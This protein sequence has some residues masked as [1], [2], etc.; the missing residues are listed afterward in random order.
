MSNVLEGTRNFLFSQPDAVKDSIALRLHPTSG[1]GYQ[2]FAENITYGSVDLHEGVDFLRDYDAPPEWLHTISGDPAVYRD[3]VMGKNVW[4]PA[5]PQFQQHLHQYVDAMK[6]VGHGLMRALA[7]GLGLRSDYFAKLTS[8]PYWSMR[9]IGY[10][11][12]MRA[13][14]VLARRPSS[15]DSVAANSVG[16][17]EHCDYGCWTLLAVDPNVQ[18]SLQVRAANGS[19]L[20]GDPVPGALVVNIGDLLSLWSGGLYQSTPHRVVNHMTLNRVS[21]PFFFDPNF[22]SPAAVLPEVQAALN[23]AKV[24][25]PRWATRLEAVRQRMGISGEKSV[26]FGQYHLKKVSSNFLL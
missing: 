19:W 3:I 15:F 12:V 4:P 1:R 14:D 10:P 7:L 22:T 11:S 6:A 18:N 20:R 2:R 24:Q 9:L 8:D 21:S 13:A 5:P 17:G 25:D 16:V 23:A 26:L